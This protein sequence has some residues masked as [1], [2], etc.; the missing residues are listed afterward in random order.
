ME[1]QKEKWIERALRKFHPKNVLQKMKQV[2]KKQQTYKQILE[3]KWNKYT[4]HPPKKKKLKHTQTHGVAK[5]S[6]FPLP[7]T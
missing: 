1:G 6:A 2:P 4:V 7:G 5:P 3:T